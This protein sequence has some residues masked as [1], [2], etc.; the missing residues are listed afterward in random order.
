M[1]AIKHRTSIT[2]KITV[3]MLPGKKK[4][5]IVIAIRQS[6]GPGIAG[7]IEPTN[8]VIFKSMTAIKR[9]IYVTY[10]MLIYYI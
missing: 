8:P 1:A 4:Y 7:V 9:R 10:C 5:T 3:E 6:G 2:I